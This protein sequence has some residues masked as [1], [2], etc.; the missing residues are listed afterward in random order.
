[1]IPTD[2]KKRLAGE[3]L[4]PQVIKK[5]KKD[6]R[7]TE[8]IEEDVFHEQFLELSRLYPTLLPELQPPADQ[9]NIFKISIN[10]Q[11]DH[12][13]DDED[14]LQEEIQYSLLQRDMLTRLD[15]RTM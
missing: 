12:E 11:D 9:K 13:D 1:M 2:N 7:G 15:S 10:L 3:M 4:Q 6:H 5:K 8:E 14:N